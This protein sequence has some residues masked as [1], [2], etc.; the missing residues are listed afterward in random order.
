MK[1]VYVREKY[2][3]KCGHE[4]TMYLTSRENSNDFSASVELNTLYTVDRERTSEVLAQVEQAITRTP[5]AV[6]RKYAAA[7]KAREKALEELKKAMQKYAEA[8]S[9]GL[10]LEHAGRIFSYTPPV[11]TECEWVRRPL[12]RYGDNGTDEISNDVYSASICISSGERSWRDKTI[13][14]TVSWSVNTNSPV[15]GGHAVIK[16]VNDKIFFSQEDA[17]RYVSGRKTF[18]KKTY[19]WEQNPVIPTELAPYYMDDG[20]KLPFYRY[21]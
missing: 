11:N 17:E 18:L 5:T 10:V 8:F 21:A 14:W 20:V 9:Q 3:C 2:Q 7:E 13:V 16:C 19:F 12:S 15:N 6:Q 4:A 1:E